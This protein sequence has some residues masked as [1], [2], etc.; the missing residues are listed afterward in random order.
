MSNMLSKRVCAVL[1]CLGL[2]GPVFA[3][4]LSI[5][6][7]P[8]PAQ[9]GQSIGVDVMISGIQDLYG[10]Q[11]SLSFNPA[12]LQANGGTEGSFLSAG[13]N[14]FFDAGTVD[15]SAGTVSYAFDTLLS[16]VPGV[17][18]SGTLIHLNFTALSAGT[19]ALNFSD[20]IFLN[21]LSADINVT[22]QPGSLTLVTTVPEPASLALLM[23]GLGFVAWRRRSAA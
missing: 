9:V 1:T 4:Q 20:V 14:T 10:Y 12:L 3:Q 15:N 18:G 16:A 2:A 7:S 17:S 23:A 11:F 6:A 8:N 5:S 13:G 21:S 22:A 19:A